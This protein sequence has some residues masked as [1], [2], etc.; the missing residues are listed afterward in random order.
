M[1]KVLIRCLAIIMVCV[2]LLSCLSGCSVVSKWSG[3]YKSKILAF[4]GL[5]GLKKPNYEFIH[6][7]NIYCD[8]FG[9]IEYAEFENNFDPFKY[10]YGH[11]SFYSI[12]S[13]NVGEIMQWIEKL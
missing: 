10:R 8:I 5:Q 11:P 4:R 7:E 2:C 13:V 3:F 1:K 6:N 9:N 12:K